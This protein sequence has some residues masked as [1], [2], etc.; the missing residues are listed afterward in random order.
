MKIGIVSDTHRNREYLIN[1]IDWMIS[2]QKISSLYHLGDDFDDLGD[3][4]DTFL[5]VVQVPGI[6]DERYK[7]GSLPAKIFET[8]L[9]LNIL[10]VHFLEKDASPDDI[11][12]SDII[13]YG[14]THK[15]EL[16]LGDGKLFCNPGHMKGPMEKNAPP[17]FAV[18]GIEDRTVIVN[19]Y[20]MQFR[21]IQSM[22]LI[23]S[24]SGLYKT[25]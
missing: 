15:E 22:E 2:R 17:T 6:Y 18:L 14:H 20:N 24:E 12:R 3:L 21:S 5:E 13:L 25:A 1:A 4:S 16:R 23:R 10:L 11:Q 7:N 19:I 9:G 8:V